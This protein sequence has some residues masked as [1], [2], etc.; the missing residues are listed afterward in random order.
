MASHESHEEFH[1]ECRLCRAELEESHREAMAG[2]RYRA[3]REL[4]Q[5]M[6]L[7]RADLD[8]GLDV[9]EAQLMAAIQR[10]FKR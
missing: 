10:R 1:Y 8:A 3:E 9:D 4:K 5:A 2:G 6:A 7:A